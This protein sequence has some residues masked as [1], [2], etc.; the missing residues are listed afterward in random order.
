[1]SSWFD[2]FNNEFQGVFILAIVLGIVGVFS[3]SMVIILVN[4]MPWSAHTMLLFF[5]SFWLIV[6]DGSFAISVVCIGSAHD[7]PGI[8]DWDWKLREFA[9]VLRIFSGVALTS[10]CLLIGFIIFYVVYYR[11]VFNSLKHKPTGRQ[12]GRRRQCPQ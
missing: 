6:Y 3:S 12:D 5:M 8:H 10:Y 9:A 11:D 4:R 7:Q 2:G 1:M